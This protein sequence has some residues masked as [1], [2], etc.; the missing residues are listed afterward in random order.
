MLYDLKEGKHLE[1]QNPRTSWVGLDPIRNYEYFLND[2][3]V[4]RRRQRRRRTTND[5]RQTI[6]TRTKDEIC[7]FKSFGGGGFYFFLFYT[8]TA[9]EHASGHDFFLFLTSFSNLHSGAGSKRSTN[10]WLQ[11]RA[12]EG[13]QASKRAKRSEA[14]RS[15]RGQWAEQADGTGARNA[16]ITL[17][18][19]CIY[20]MW[21]WK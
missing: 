4:S 7:F 1:K 5:K 10:L 8:S 16:P 19:Q 6:R 21:N 2:M 17:F 13:R 20:E 15:E 12:G 14:K 11:I 18:P 3:K 9:T